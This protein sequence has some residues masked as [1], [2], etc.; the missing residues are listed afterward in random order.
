[1]KISILTVFPEIYDSFL[2]TSLI[3]KAIEK[4][5]VEFNIVRFSDMCAPKERIDEPTVGPGVG[6]ILKPDIIE[7]A[8]LDAESKWG[9]GYKVFFSPKGKRLTQPEL[10]KQASNFSSIQVDASDDHLILVCPRYEG[11]DARVVEHY[12]D[13]VVSIGDYVLMGGDLPAQVYLEGFLRLVPGVIGNMKSVL[14]D[15]F[16]GAFLDHPQ[17]GLP[18]DWNKKSIP[19]VLRS[20]DHA[21]IKEWRDDAA[22]KD[23]VLN[24]FDW[25]RS[26]ANK[27]DRAV[28]KKFIPEHY[29]ALMHK[30]ILIKGGRVGHTSITS[31]DIH[32]IARSG[33][34]YGVKNSFVVSALKDQHAI[35]S[36]FLGFWSSPEG[37]AYNPKR[38]DAI[39]RI[40]P[41]SS[42]EE[43]VEKIGQ[44]PIIVA[45]SAQRHDKIETLDY[46]SQK[47]LW[48]SGRPI[49][50]VFGT[51]QGLSN[52]IL[53]QCDYLLGPI[54]GVDDFNHLSVR[55]A[56]AIVLDRLLGINQ[57]S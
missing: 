19:E 35:M 22:A 10:K 57:A 39:S 3:A 17:Y 2:T 25:F 41:T 28:G 43:V 56:V 16:E 51:G 31:L 12:A 30:D 23:T 52:L 42:L 9:K 36:E 50:L 40:V 20:G 49:L 11:L 8:I 14:E 44:K 46:Y 45:T 5:L 32:D 7:K 27:A 33:A 37:R 26:H 55:S 34:T 29:V 1:M 24:R 4:G 48:S 18:V 38:Y 6:M 21:K 15:S 53:D 54:E 13:E 47:Q